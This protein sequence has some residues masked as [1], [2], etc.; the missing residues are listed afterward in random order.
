[1]RQA[2]LRGSTS[3]SLSCE[4]HHDSVTEKIP[5]LFISFDKN[6]KVH[7][8]Y[9]PC[10][11]FRKRSWCGSGF[12]LRPTKKESA[13]TILARMVYTVVPAFYNHGSLHPPV[14]Q[15]TTSPPTKTIFLY[16]IWHPSEADSAHSSA[17][18]SEA[19]PS[20]PDMTH[21]RELV[22]RGRLEPAMYKTV[23]GHHRQKYLI[24][25]ATCQRETHPRYTSSREPT[26]WQAY[27][28]AKRAGKGKA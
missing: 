24:Q 20:K 7:S 1:M 18:E 16:I 13:R 26:S 21:V 15:N 5:G 11:P 3:C 8:C 14:D 4:Y 19:H 6:I 12:M 25:N 22:A 27:C 2:I 10:V 9:F 23:P 17:Q 28:S